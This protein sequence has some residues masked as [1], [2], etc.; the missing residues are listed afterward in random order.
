MLRNLV[1]G[2]GTAV[3]P[4][5]HAAQRHPCALQANSQK[6]RCEA[7]QYAELCAFH[8]IASLLWW[9][10]AV[11]LSVL[12]KRVYSSALSLAAMMHKA[13]AA[14]LRCSRAVQLC[15]T[16]CGAAF[17]SRGDDLQQTAQ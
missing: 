4:A 2:K 7:G 14:A 1:L 6:R 5:I 3:R 16:A 15:A 8:V 17:A 11:L 13:S 9:C 12:S 10:N